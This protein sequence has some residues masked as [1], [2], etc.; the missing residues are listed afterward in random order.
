MKKEKKTFTIFIKNLPHKNDIFNKEDVLKDFRKLIIAS[1]KCY[2]FYQFRTM[3]ELF[4]FEDSEILE[5]ITEET[6]NLC[7]TLIN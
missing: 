2:A 6:T 3:P 1:E 5:M 7:K 4:R